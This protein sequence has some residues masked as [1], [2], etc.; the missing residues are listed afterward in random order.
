MSIRKET[1][2]TYTLDYYY[3]DVVSGEK[4]KTKKRGFRTKAEA[5]AFERSLSRD[6]SDVLF[7]SLFNELQEI[8]EQ[9]KETLEGKISNINK[10]LP[11]F[12]T[13]KYSQL[14]K[15]YLLKVRN[16]LAQ[17]EISAKTKNK[18]LN[19][20]TSTCKYAH[21]IYDLADNSK[22]LDRFK[23]EKKEFNVWTPEE[24]FKFEHELYNTPYNDLIPI[25]HTLFF[26][27]MRK[28]EARALT[29]NDLDVD[30]GIITINKSMR[31][32]ITTLKAPKTPSGVRKIKIDKNTLELLKPLKTNEKWLFGDFA[33]TSKIRLEKALKIGTDAAALK[34]IRIHDFRHSHATYLILN[35]ANIVAV[36]KRL[37]HKS[38]DMTLSTYTHLFENAENQVI[39]L[40]NNI[41]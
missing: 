18:I 37:G 26:T 6:E 22:V 16:D 21:K 23:I 5:K 38:I 36:S 30:N 14:T 39:E 41:K 35:G 17:K 28:G 11:G 33:P 29:I 25:F 7:I 2:G 10:Y 4:K 34:K 20:I 31:E 3:L 9:E 27:G 15:P 8:T 32:D 12:K 19:I 1:N 40:L 24:Y 13:I